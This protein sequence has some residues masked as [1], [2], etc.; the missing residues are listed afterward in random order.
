MASPQ[1]QSFAQRRHPGFLCS[2]NQCLMRKFGALFY[3]IGASLLVTCPSRQGPMHEREWRF[4][5]A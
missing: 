3:T 4:P 1:R 5:R 2:D